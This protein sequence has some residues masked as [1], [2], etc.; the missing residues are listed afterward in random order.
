M[1]KYQEAMNWIVDEY[2]D[3]D[4]Q[5]KAMNKDTEAAFCIQEL[6]NKAT[7]KKPIKR[8][9]GKEGDEPYIKTTCPNGCHITLW[10]NH[11]F[12]PLCGQA[13]DWSDEK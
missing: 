4:Y 2:L 7:P 5:G 1:N 10:Y 13:V 8:H 3:I 9:Y 11:K 12:C 6:I